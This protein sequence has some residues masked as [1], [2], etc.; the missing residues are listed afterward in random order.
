M[1]VH[2][3]E[4][5][6][7]ERAATFAAVLGSLP[8]VTVTEEVVDPGRLSGE[9]AVDPSGVTYRELTR[10][11]SGARVQGLVSRGA[12]VA[13]DSCGCRG[14]C[15]V[16]WLDESQR[17]AVVA[18]PVPRVRP[19]DRPMASMSEWRAEDGSSLVVLAG[20]VRWGGPPSS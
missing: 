12:L 1:T 17:A 11:I 16:D 14:Y 18:G 7:R 19:R 3:G 9:V 10:D 15:P 6:R 4:V 8:P 5:S 13:W 2:P 20:P